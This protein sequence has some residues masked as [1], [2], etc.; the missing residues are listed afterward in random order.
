MSTLFEAVFEDTISNYENLMTDYGGEILSIFFVNYE[1]MRIGVFI[2]LKV[3]NRVFCVLKCVGL[4]FLPKFE[5]VSRNN[6][7]KVLIRVFSMLNCVGHT[8]SLLFEAFSMSP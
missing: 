1:K 8:L 2:C 5:A 4:T 7:V 3:V 6:Y